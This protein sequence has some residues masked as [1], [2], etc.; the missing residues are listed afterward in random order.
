LTYE[1]KTEQKIFVCSETVALNAL[2]EGAEEISIELTPDE[3]GIVIR[4]VV[5]GGVIEMKPYPTGLEYKTGE[6]R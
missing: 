1:T 5:R 3:K 6:S 4:P 2:F